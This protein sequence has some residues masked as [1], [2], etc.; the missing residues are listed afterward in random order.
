VSLSFPIQLLLVED[1]AGD[2]LLVESLLTGVAPNVDVLRVER[3]QE[4]EEMLP[5]GIDCVLLDLGLPDAMGLEA[6]ERLRAAAPDA[7]IVVLTGHHDEQR[8]V[9]ALS[10]GAEDYLVKG[11]VDGPLLARAIR[12][13]IERCRAD[14]SQRELFEARLHA[15]EN[16]RLERG[17]LPQALLRDPRIALSATYRPGR[18]R[19]LLGGDFYDAVEL[20]DGTLHVL[21][22]DVS[23]HGPD[24]AALGA[25]LRVA[26]RTL[27]LAQSPPDEALALLQEV[28]LHERH[29]PAIFAT[30]CMLSVAPDR[31]A[32]EVRLAGHPPP[33]LVDRE[34]L[35]ALEPAH[36]TPPLGFVEPGGWRGNPLRFAGDWALVLYT[37]GLIDGRIGE[38][39]ERL[40]EQRLVELIAQ[41]VDGDIGQLEDA[42]PLLDELVTEVE[43]LHGGDLTDDVAMVVVATRR[44]A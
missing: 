18:R 10:R 35:R 41:R 44:G 9:D 2:A 3:L 26:W 25:C 13:A 21:I 6:V 8:G 43:R 39:P 15:R 5:G 11:S 17:L 29:A 22:G 28:L 40:G 42:S 7:A 16:A 1:D 12:Y 34:G 31:A 32:G 14:R 36:V 38:G 23:G 27:M 19:A 37:D 30:L 24:E 4:A 20:G 33:V